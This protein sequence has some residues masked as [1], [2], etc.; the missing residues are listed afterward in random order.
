M[1]LW[2]SSPEWNRCTWIWKKLTGEPPGD[3]Y[4]HADGQT[5]CHGGSLSKNGDKCEVDIP[6]VVQADHEGDWFCEL[7]IFKPY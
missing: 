3:C 1:T 2:C 5:A 6:S 4:L 7:G